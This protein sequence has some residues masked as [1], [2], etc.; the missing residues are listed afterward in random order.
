MTAEL[1]DDQRATIA[2]HAKAYTEKAVADFLG[3]LKAKDAD[4]ARAALVGIFGDQL[5]NKPDMPWQLYL[6][7]LR[8]VDLDMRDIVQRIMGEWISAPN[9]FEPSDTVH[10]TTVGTQGFLVATAAA[11]EEVLGLHAAAHRETK[12][13][14][15]HGIQIGEFISDEWRRKAEQ[16]TPVTHIRDQIDELEE[17]CAAI[18]D[19]IAHAEATIAEGEPKLDAIAAKLAAL[20]ALHLKRACEREG[21]PLGRRQLATKKARKSAPGCS[22]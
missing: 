4:E 18:R 16:G 5:G 22:N 21:L 7:P 15:R 12:H 11:I 20:E 19:D 2:R 14:Y 1:S 3:H 13:P 6:D 8:R 10:R 17:K 9:T